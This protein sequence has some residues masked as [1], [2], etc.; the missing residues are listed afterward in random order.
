M[1]IGLAL[2]S[3]GPKGLAHIGVIK[4]LLR[5]GITPE[6]ITGSS[7]GALI[8]GAYSVFGSIEEM[9]KL[10]YSSDMKTIL[11]VLFDPTLNLGL[12]NGQK[13]MKFFRE[14]IGDP[15]IESLS[16]KF[17]PVA[18][19]LITGEP[20]VFERGSFAEAVRASISLPVIFQPVKM[21]GMLLV[22]GGLTQNVPAE[23]A[24]ERGADFVIG[25]NLNSRLSHSYYGFAK[26]PVGLYKIASE[27]IDIFQY[28]LAKENCRHA[29]F[30]IKP[31][32]YDVGWDSF[33]KP[34]KVIKEGERAAERALPGLLKSIRKFRRLQGLKKKKG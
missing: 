11:S 7:I 10:A 5:N 8:G 29:D 33:L 30:V 18:T 27:S 22:D 1:K 24:R 21:R 34:K 15:R 2:G 12:L 25:V 20:F 19:D 13:A 23:A 9:E 6:I 4:V 16:P 32:V 28:N 31:K 3:G 14:K 17:Y 26:S